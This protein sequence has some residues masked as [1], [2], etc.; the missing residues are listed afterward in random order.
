MY[1]MLHM[2]DT[3]NKPYNARVDKISVGNRKSPDDQGAQDSQNEENGPEVERGERYKRKNRRFRNIAQNIARIAKSSNQKDLQTAF[4]ESGISDPD[5]ESNKMDVSDIGVLVATSLIFDGL[6][7]IICLLD[8]VVPFLGT[9]IEKVTIFPLSTLTLYLMYKKR[10]V[11]FSSKILVR[12]WGSRL[13]GFIPY[14]SLLPEY[15]LGTALIVL[16]VKAEEL[17]GLKRITEEHP[18]IMKYLQRYLK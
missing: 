10:G 18:E 15:T 14:L 12:F 16:S 13:I 5:A 7:F 6:A 4:K 17:T 8:F 2:A 3:L 1:N 9:I 11:N